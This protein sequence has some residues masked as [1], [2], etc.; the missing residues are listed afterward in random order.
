MAQTHSELEFFIGE[1]RVCG[2]VRSHRRKVEEEN[3]G[4]VRSRGPKGVAKCKG[5]GAVRRM[6]TS[7]F[8]SEIYEKEI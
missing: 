2:P 4:S 6:K 5:E 1:H 8:A 7:A 3:L